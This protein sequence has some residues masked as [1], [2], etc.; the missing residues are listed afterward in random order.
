MKENIK[1]IIQ[2]AA[3]ATYVFILVLL[4]LLTTG[5]IFIKSVEKINREIGNQQTFSVQGYSKKKV[6]L[7]TA[8]ITLGVVLE[9]KSP[10]EVQRRASE[11]YNKAIEAIKQVGIEEK[12]IQT[13][14]YNV[15]TLY[16][17]ETQEIRGY[18]ID[19]SLIVT[20][21][22][23]NPESE[24]ITKIINAASENGFNAVNNLQFYLEDYQAVQ[25]EIKE[26]AIN[27]AKERALREAQ[28]AGL[29]LGDVVNMY[30]DNVY[31]YYERSEG[32]AMEANTKDYAIEEPL[33]AIEIQ[34]GET[35]VNSTVTLVFEIK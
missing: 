17:F 30:S 6:A 20:V 22:D 4:S 11:R 16:E 5:I 8:K 3:K 29:N 24:L 35:E 31:P 9:D 2:F 15:R 19:L 28:A 13:Q 10:A 1:P 23:T 27:D 7:D 25:D 14:N 34:P 18:E 21:H 32:Y 33:P 12:D 26:E